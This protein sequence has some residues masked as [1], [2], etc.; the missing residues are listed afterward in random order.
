[1]CEPL[2]YTG[3]TTTISTRRHDPVLGGCSEVTISYHP[4]LGPVATHARAADLVARAF[5]AVAIAAQQRV[6]QHPSRGSC[7][8][9]GFFFKKKLVFQEI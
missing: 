9:S 8:R 3:A 7:S 6:P 4:R 1:M 5:D 2:H